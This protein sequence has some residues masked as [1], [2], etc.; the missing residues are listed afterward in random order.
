MFCCT[1]GDE[2]CILAFLLSFCLLGI[3]FQKEFAR[4]AERAEGILIRKLNFYQKLLLLSELDPN[5][6]FFPLLLTDPRVPWVK[7][8]KVIPGTFL[9]A[10]V[11]HFGQ[12]Q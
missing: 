1:P 11:Q 7:A 12:L 8:I 2:R 4:A 5:S 6:E 9:R 10:K 3:A